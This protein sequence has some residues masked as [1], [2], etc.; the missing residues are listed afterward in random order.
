MENENDRRIGKNRCLAI[1]RK[2]EVMK[3]NEVVFGFQSARECF[4]PPLVQIALCHYICNSN[5]LHCPV[6]QHKRG[7]IGKDKKGEF[8]PKKNKFFPFKLFCQMAK[9]MGKYPWSILRF[10]GRGEPL[11]HPNFVEMVEYAKKSGVGTVTSFTNATLLDDA[12]AERLLDAKIDLLELSLDTISEKTYQQVRGTENFR[13]VNT[14]AE[15]L[16]RRRNA[17]GSDCQTRV[18]V[19]AVDSPEF[20]L[21]KKFFLN[22][23]KTYADEAI[24]RP[25]HTYGGRLKPLPRGDEKVVPCAQLW[26]RFSVN[27][28]GKVNACFN[29]WADN[30][31]VGDL[32]PR[33]AKISSIWRSERFEAIRE[34]ALKG[35]CNLSCCG[36]CLAAI[37][38]WNYSYQLLIKKL[39]SRAPNRK[40]K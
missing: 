11:L 6:G 21:E 29:D 12:M 34:E 28:F 5:C 25:Y 24:V 14:N 38:G 19:S 31:I 27:P 35:K 40:L 8:D 23:W 18:I 15:N 36:N 4:F 39:K 30:D 13:L 16:I 33:G 17:R 9:E 1:K 2:E 3:K 37:S 32:R 22:Y 20:Q 10:H 26:T 7:L